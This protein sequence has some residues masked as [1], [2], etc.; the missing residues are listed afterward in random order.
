MP[1]FDFTDPDGRQYTVN[2][3]DGATPEQA[4]AI[5]QQHLSTTAPQQPSQGAPSIATA[6]QIA[7]ARSTGYADADIVN[8]LSQ[9][10]PDKFK[11]ATEAGYTPTEILDHLTQSGLPQSPTPVTN[12]E[13][14]KKL[15]QQPDHQLT[16]VAKGAAKGLAEGAEGLAGL[17]GDLE[18]GVDWLADKVL[19]LPQG[20][21]PHPSGLAPP[22]TDQVDS[23]VG[24]SKLPAPQTTAGQRTENIASFVPAALGGEGGVVKSALLRGVLP[25]AASELAGEATQGTPLE[26]PARIAAAMLMPSVAK[27]SASI[28]TAE[29]LRSAADAGYSAARSMPVDLKPSSVTNWADRTAV[30]LAQNG[31]NA[32]LAPNT[33]DVLSEIQNVPSGAASIGLDNVDTMRRTLGNIAGNYNNPTDQAAASRAIKSLDDYVTGLQPTD[34]ISGDAATAAKTWSDA[35]ANYAA[36]KRAEIVSNA[37]SAADDAAGATGTSNTGNAIR[38]QFKKL[39]ASSAAGQGFNPDELAQVSNI[40]RGSVT[41]NLLR[42]AAKGLGGYGGVMQGLAAGAGG[43][44]GSETDEPGGAA[45]GAVLPLILGVLARRGANASVTRNVAALDAMTR[46]RS[47]L[48]QAAG[49]VSAP[50]GFAGLSWPQRILNA[51]R[52]LHSGDPQ[53]GGQQQ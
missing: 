49:V 1:T 40:V 31:F 34:V 45:A 14:L 35:R 8:Y 11:A 13:V 16:D 38:Q 24:A 21:D 20:V 41:G 23:L 10:A 33:H 15:N 39:L 47:P 25:G 42:S 30:D 9:R 37:L 19:P 50:R 22:S 3:P 48:A 27:S 43:Y 6:D 12:P 32:K 5:L 26:L 36:A 51:A 18:R 46:A 4:F 17:P 44:L 2:G 28:P 7:Q 53:Q 52:A 29:E